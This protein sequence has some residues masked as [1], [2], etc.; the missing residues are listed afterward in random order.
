MERVL[1]P[2][3]LKRGYQRVVSNKGHRVAAM[4]A[5]LDEGPQP[6][7]ACLDEAR[8][9]KSTV[10]GRGPWWNSAAPRMNQALPKKLWD[11]LGLVS[12]LDTINGL[13]A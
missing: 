10:N 11:G 8:A 7:P 13:S 9:W 5:T 12:I 6:D 4:E 2:A 3:N 1:A